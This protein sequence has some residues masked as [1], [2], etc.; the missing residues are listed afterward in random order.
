[1]RGEGGGAGLKIIFVHILDR[2]S[3]I[4]V[5]SGKIVYNFLVIAMSPALV[6]YGYLDSGRIFNNHHR[7]TNQ[8]L[9]DLCPVC[10]S[11]QFDT[12]V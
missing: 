11:G 8:S 1:M 10:E 4:N 3:L 2:M 6:K 12:N 7:L 9:F 5:L